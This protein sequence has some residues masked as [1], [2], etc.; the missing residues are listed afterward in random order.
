MATDSATARD[1]KAAQ[2]E[3]TGASRKGEQQQ[4]LQNLNYEIL[5]IGLSLLSVLNIG[6]ALVVQD[7][8]VRHIIDIINAPLTAIFFIDFLIRL[9][10]A[11]SKPHYFFRENGWADLAASLW[12]PALKILRLF[13]VIRAW[14]MIRRYGPKNMI[15]QL[16][17]HRADA[18]LSV[19]TF[20][21]VLVLE[22]GG[23]FVVISERSN[24]DANIKSASDAIWWAFVTI[25]TVGYGDRYPTTN[26]GR[27]VGML[28]MTTGVGLFGVLTGY[29]ANAFLSPGK[30][31]ED[32]KQ[33]TEQ[34]TVQTTAQTTAQAQADSQSM[35]V[36]MKRL[37]SEQEKAQEELRAM[38]AELKQVP[39]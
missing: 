25:T 10:S 39:R 15:R 4:E 1:G 7:P 14:R 2:T 12:F 37:L 24:P 32:D 27:F 31:A 3:E 20:L 17:E 34:Q 22:F 6:I 16:N 29:L 36:E 28:V 30:K 13:R 19:I 26:W 38:L 9:R 18:A 5:L 33:N 23:I 21:I 35:L 8:V 11:K